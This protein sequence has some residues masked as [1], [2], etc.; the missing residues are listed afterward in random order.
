MRNKRQTFDKVKKHL[1]KQGERSMKADD[2]ICVYHSKEGLK[3]A[4]GCLISEEDYKRSFEQ[5]SVFDLERKLGT[6][7][8]ETIL[9]M[10]ISDE[11][12]MMLFDLQAVHDDVPPK[13]WEKKLKQL[14]KRYFSK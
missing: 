6:K 9:N 13:Q 14:E 5:K 1:L 7:K 8:L 2:S 3:C 4:V 10:K 11:S 12:I